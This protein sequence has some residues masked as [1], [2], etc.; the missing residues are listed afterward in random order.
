M[1]SSPARATSQVEWLSHSVHVGALTL[2][3]ARLRVHLYLAA[4]VT[5]TPSVTRPA[6]VDTGAPLSVVPRY[7]HRQGLLWQSLPGIHAT[8]SGQRCDLGRIDIWLPTDQPSYLRG[9]FSL[10]AKFPRS[11]PPGDPVPI[12]LGL[13]F[14]LTHQA[15]LHLPLPPRDGQILIP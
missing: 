10:L 14:F 11:D 6:W 9:P 1:S 3:V 13:G 5:G 12:L 8:W 4:A 2:T 7:V 15:E